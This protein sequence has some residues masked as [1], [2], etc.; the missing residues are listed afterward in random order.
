[1]SWAG[2]RR[3]Y[4][5]QPRIDDIEFKVNDG[6]KIEDWLTPSAMLSRGRR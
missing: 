4:F 6:C 2:S 5:A 1:L 3:N